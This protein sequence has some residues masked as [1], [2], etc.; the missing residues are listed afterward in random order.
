M[1][2]QTR[3][4]VLE[5]DVSVVSMMRRYGYKVYYGDATHRSAA[6]GWS[7]TGGGYRHHL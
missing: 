4:T 2:N 5:R 6:C 3:V 7:D 1:A